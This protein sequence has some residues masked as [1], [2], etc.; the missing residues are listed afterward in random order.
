MLISIANELD[1]TVSDLLGETIE[2]NGENDLKTISK[3]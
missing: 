2:N 3:N 1:V